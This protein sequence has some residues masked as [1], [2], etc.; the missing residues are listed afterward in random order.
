MNLT[1]GTNARRAVLCVLIALSLFTIGISLGYVFSSL[2]TV[3]LP[4]AKKDTPSSAEGMVLKAQL[5]YYEKRVDDLQRLASAMLLISTLFAAVAGIT[6]YINVNQSVEKMS[7]LV[8]SAE[9]ELSEAK[10]KADSALQRL[11]KELAEIHDRAEEEM[12]EIRREFPMFGYMNHVITRI[13]SEVRALLDPDFL[14]PSVT[15]TEIFRQLA[16]E[17][18]QR[19]LFYEKT[20]AALSLMDLRAYATEMAKIYRGLG[21]FFGSK[22]YS[23]GQTVNDEDLEK[24]TFYFDRANRVDV[25]SAATLNDMAYFILNPQNPNSLI[26]AEEILRRSLDLLDN[27]QRARMNLAYIKIIR[28]DYEEAASILEEALRRTSWE[29]GNDAPHPYDIKYNYACAL[30]GLQRYD[31]AIQYLEES[32]DPFRH[33]M[34][35][36]LKRN[37]ADPDDEIRKLANVEGYGQRVHAIVERG[38]RDFGRV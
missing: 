32:F 6:T 36:T 1:S 37:L 15:K 27:Q 34:W 4:P 38:E 28:R 23:Y 17:K 9:K 26:K 21:L 20:V 13:V 7:M 2:Q 31:E 25:D 18:R 8:S 12:T 11:D 35:E 19:I 24:A 3:T 5:D 10:I 22:A 16:P 29:T 14:L 30:A 33:E